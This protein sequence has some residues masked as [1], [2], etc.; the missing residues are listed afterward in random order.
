MIFSLI[1]KNQRHEYIMKTLNSN[2]LIIVFISLECIQLSI[3]MIMNTN[4]H[5]STG[6]YCSQAVK[7]AVVN[8]FFKAEVRYGNG[9]QK[10]MAEL[11]PL[12]VFAYF[13]QNNKII[14]I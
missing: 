10:Q 13:E 1:Y 9:S 2:F 7:S 8:L 5:I 11:R 12:I 6:T 3:P 14:K 4:Q